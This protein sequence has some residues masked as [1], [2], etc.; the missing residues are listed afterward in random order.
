MTVKKASIILIIIVIFVVIVGISLI[1]RGNEDKYTIATVERGTIL[2]TV[3]E[4]GTLK[5][6]KELDLSFPVSGKLNKVYVKIGDKV[7]TSKVLAELDYSDLEIRKN[8]A[9]ANVDVATENINKLYAGAT[10]EEIAISE[11]SMDQAKTAYEAA[12]NEYKKIDE[13]TKESVDQAQKNLSDIESKTSLDVTTYEQSVIS[14]EDALANEKTLYQKEISDKKA[15]AITIIEDKLSI[16]KTDLDVINQT[17]TDEDSKDY[18][19]KRAPQYLDDT[20]AQYNQALEKLEI[21]EVVLGDLKINNDQVEIVEAL[22]DTVDI[23]R[24]IFSSLLNCYNALENSVTSNNF[25]QATLDSYKAS[26]IVQQ[27]LLAAAQKSTEGSLEN[28]NDAILNYSTKIN[29]ASNNLLT[30][31]TALSNALLNYKN[32]LR[33]AETSRAQQIVSAQAKIDSA[34]KAWQVTI[35]QLNKVKAPANTYDV[36]LANARLR[37]SQASYDTIVNQISDSILKAPSAGVITGLNSEVGEQVNPSRTLITLLSDSQFEIEVLVS[38]ADIAKI[39]IGNN[40]EITLDSYGDDVKFVGKIVFVEPAETVIQD[41]I[42]YK[43]NI[44]FD[45]KGLSV[46]SGM[47]A[48]VTIVTA[49]KKNVLF[50]PSRAIIQKNGSG[51][52]ARVL[53]N[54]QLVEKKVEIGL[55]GDDG[56][57]EIVGGVLEGETVVTYIQSKK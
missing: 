2:Q 57:Y 19:S 38:E 20:K 25:S 12:Q 6:V 4:T 52:Y 42:Y 11:A 41:V 43:I 21:L 51:K 1:P 5:A 35:A 48:N 18:I 3:S 50:V 14:A 44:N 9:K 23:L 36:K 26:I 24:L 31:K 34:Y 56:V 29:T 17:I 13:S 39:K 45:P 22:D 40:S 53:E 7:S 47:T 10:R 27:T 37:Q 15:V 8:E 28:L 30:A 54:G 55:R 33:T 49:E 46:K 16:S 32:V